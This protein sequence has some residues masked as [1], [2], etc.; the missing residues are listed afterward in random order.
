M[1]LEIEKRNGFFKTKEIWFADYP[2]DISE[3]ARVVFQDC[4]NK[5]DIPGFYCGEFTTLVI[6]LTQDLDT[7]WKNME[8]KS[9]RY[10]VNRAIREGI[11]I[12]LNKDYQEFYEINRLFRKERKLPGFTDLAFMKKYGTLFIAELNGGIIGGQLYLEDKDNIRWL[13]GASKRLEVDKKKATLIGCGNRLIVWEAIKYAKEKG[14]KEFDFGGYYTGEEDKEKE[15]INIFKK[16]FGGKLTLHYIYQKNYSNIC[17]L[18][19]W[20]CNKLKWKV[21]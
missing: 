17:K 12:R 3:I 19:L 15:K 16:S 18:A 14:L 11:K 6:D 1:A 13:I 9:C 21:K 20:A 4:K 8:Y 10:C 7:I 2:F 5:V